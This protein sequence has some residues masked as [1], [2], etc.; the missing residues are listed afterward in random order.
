MAWCAGGIRNLRA[1]R[2]TPVKG[3]GGVVGIK[4]GI[5][6]H[7]ST[8]EINILRLIYFAVYFHVHICYWIP[9][10]RSSRVE[11][12]WELRTQQTADARLKGSEFRYTSEIS[13]G[14]WS[15]QHHA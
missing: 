4:R 6:L 15:Y 5:F 10:A 12:S 3:D 2:R 14:S 7:A 1:V 11:S 13:G 9:E 8:K